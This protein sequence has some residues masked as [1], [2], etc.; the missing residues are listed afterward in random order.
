[1]GNNQLPPTDPR[2]RF[3]ERYIPEPNSGCWL[4]LGKIGNN[5]YAYLHIYRTASIYA[6]RFSLQMATTEEGAGLE[7]CHRCDN[8]LC[9]N[10][11]HLFWGTQKDNNHDAMLKGRIRNASFYRT[12]CP[13]GHP[14]DGANTYWSR[15]GWRQCRTCMVARTRVWRARSKMNV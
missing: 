11:D 15:K 9:V 12:H 2:V 10:P 5:G 4:W 1:M 8:P 13:Q 7:A 6:H 14:Y 3:D